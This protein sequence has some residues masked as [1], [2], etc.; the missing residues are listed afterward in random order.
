MVFIMFKIQSLK[1]K[2]SGGFWCIYVYPDTA[3]DNTLLICSLLGH[4]WFRGLERRPKLTGLTEARSSRHRTDPP[5]AFSLPGPSYP[6]Q[7]PDWRCIDELVSKALSLSQDLDTG[8]QQKCW[9]TSFECWILLTEGVHQNS[10]W[11]RSK[12]ML[13]LWD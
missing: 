2:K 9:V 8:I 4:L 6:T 10:P 3:S 1:R 12:V 13:A 5:A 7:T 11:W